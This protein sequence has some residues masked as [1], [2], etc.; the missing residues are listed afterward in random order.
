MD[1][2]TILDLGQTVYFIKGGKSIQKATVSRITIHVKAE[3][4]SIVYEV[5]H[6]DVQ[7]YTIKTDFTEEKDL[8]KLFHTKEAAVAKLIQDILKQVGNING[9]S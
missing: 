6:K 8:T 1:I 4:K 3:G 9:T 5:R 7:S 2:K